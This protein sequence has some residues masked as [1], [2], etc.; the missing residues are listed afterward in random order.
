MRRMNTMYRAQATEL[1]RS[2]RLL[3][4]AAVLL[5][6]FGLVAADSVEGFGAYALVTTA[7]LL[8]FVLWLRGGAAGVPVLA[9]V[10]ALHYLFY[11]VP[12]LRGQETHEPWEVLRAAATVAFF[13]GAATLASRLVSNQS[14]Q[15]LQRTS[16]DF[17]SG[18]KIR[19]YALGGIA[20]GV[21][22]YLALMSE[23]LNWLGP[24]FGIVRSVT[25]SAASIGC[26][27]LGY[28]RA[29]GLL[30]G[31]AWGLALAGF[32]GLVMLSC[33]SLFLVGGMT[34]GLTAVLG[35]FLTSRRIPWTALAA[36]VAVLFVLHAGK[37]EI[38]D[39]YWIG[40]YTQETSIAEIPGLFAEWFAAGVGA[41][42][43]GQVEHNIIDRASLL[44]ILILVE[45]A[46]PEQIPYLGGETYALLPNYLVPRFLKPDKTFS[47]AGL[48]LLNIRYGLQTE[49]EVRFTTIG[50]GLISEAY[51]NFGYGGVFG[52][53]L[54]IGALA[55]LFTRFSAGAPPLAMP[56]LLS[57]AALACLTNLEADLSYLLVTL[58][59]A[60]VAVSVF[61]VPLKLLSG[62]EKQRALG[63]AVATSRRLSTSLNA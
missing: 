44:D 45:R 18:A 43:T 9:A 49:E 42:A 19:R 34:F 8:P 5:T 11:A 16:A 50:W 53:G 10:A 48:A 21:L 2:W 47:Q 7:T 56:T 40:G 60:L 13:L 23:W 33:S 41:I 51:A 58:W 46:T 31:V 6:L 59:Q 55:T 12:I 4:G 54:L 36:M 27:L 61:F 26:Y 37:G 39:R 14:F 22:F 20:V 30:R 57:L 38:R 25:L 29:R 24:Y 62:G 3:G 28:S 32:A 1:R 52:V 17:M 63:R 15:R 35:Y